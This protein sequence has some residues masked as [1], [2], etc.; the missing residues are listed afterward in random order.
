MCKRQRDVEA[1][2]TILPI[3][4]SLAAQADQLTCKPALL[5]FVETCVERLGGIG[6]TFHIGCPAGHPAGSNLAKQQQDQQNDNH[7]S[8]VAAAVIASAVETAAA[9]AAEPSQ[10]GDDQDDEKNGAE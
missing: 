4:F 5:L 7:N 8:E 10:Q 9:D 3:R 1:G 2:R 6:E